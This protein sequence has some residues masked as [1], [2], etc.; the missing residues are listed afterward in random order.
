[1]LAP[2][3]LLLSWLG[4]AAFLRN[5]RERILV[6]YSG[7]A[8][9]IDGL[10]WLYDQLTANT[11]NCYLAFHHKAGHGIFAALVV[12]VLVCW[13]ARSQRI[14]AALCAFAALHLHILCDFAGSQGADGY[15]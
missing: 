15:H 8:A 1:M 13:L 7:L 2:N 10:G 5:R 14:T 3:H 9:D 6:A 4:A 11:S 12:A